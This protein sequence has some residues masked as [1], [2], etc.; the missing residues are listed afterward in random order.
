LEYK[1]KIRQLRTIRPDIS[2]TS[3]FIVGFPGETDQDFEATMN[4]VHDIG[5]DQSFSFI[6]SQRPG[7]PA[8]NLPDDVPMEVK[9][10]RLN[11]LQDRLMQQARELSFK[12]VG[13]KESVLIMGPS[14]K[15]KKE[16]YGRTDNN[17]VVN[18]KGKPNQQIG[19][20]I[21]VQVT[22]VV[23]NSLRGDVL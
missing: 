15:D 2:I 9:K 13:K 14:K 12:M 16:L 22:E 17:R 8:A 11:I 7:T 19:D 4:L 20:L 6:Y 21:Q 18:F 23:G 10:N 1:A 3:D 5:F